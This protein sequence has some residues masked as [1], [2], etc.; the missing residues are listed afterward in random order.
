LKRVADN[1]KSEPPKR[2]SSILAGLDKWAVLGNLRRAKPET[3]SATA[4]PTPQKTKYSEAFASFANFGT[5]K[6]QKSDVQSKSRD[7]APSWRQCSPQRLRSTSMNK[8]QVWERSSKEHSPTHP[9]PAWE[10]D[11]NWREHRPPVLN[12]PLPSLPPS[13]FPAGWTNA[14]RKSEKHFLDSK[15]EDGDVEWVVGGW[16][17]F[18]L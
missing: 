10:L 9:P 14:N 5:S 18:N 7:R 4:T 15:F 3:A 2:N 8:S 13:K 17:D 1:E 12:K 11:N 6:K 16:K